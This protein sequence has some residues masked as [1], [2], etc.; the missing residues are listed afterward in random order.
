MWTADVRFGDIYDIREFI[1]PY[2]LA[3]RRLTEKLISG[4]ESEEEKVLACWKWVVEEID[5]PLDHDGNNSDACVLLS[6]YTG[7]GGNDIRAISKALS[8]K[9][10]D[11]FKLRL[12]QT[13]FWQMPAEVLGWRN[14]AGRL[15]G[16]CEGS[17]VALVSMMRYFTDEVYAHLGTVGGYGHCWAEWR[18]SI[19]ETT[20]DRLPGGGNVGITEVIESQSPHDY[21][22]DAKFND[23]V[24]EGDLSRFKGFSVG[25][26]SEAEYCWG[27]RSKISRMRGIAVC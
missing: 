20:L 25:A 15:M 18:G 24:F 26:L 19:L 22:S 8:R 13:D 4:K 2:N 12:G 1:T 5:Y 6:C 23:R 3:V 9:N 10:L 11:K 17:S 21:R 7:S 27:V 16:D 14:T